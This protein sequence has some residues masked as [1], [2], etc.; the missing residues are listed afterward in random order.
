MQTMH[1]NILI[2]PRTEMKGVYTGK[3][4][5]YL[6]V[7]RPVLGLVDNDDVAAE[8]IRAMNAGYVA[9][10]SSIEEI[11]NEI[12]HLFEDWRNNNLRIPDLEKVQLLHRKEGVKKLKNLI[13]ELCVI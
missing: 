7:C 3:L 10:F 4:Y 12:L 1:A 13:N 6:S 9:E 8:L 2:H 11:E 5:D